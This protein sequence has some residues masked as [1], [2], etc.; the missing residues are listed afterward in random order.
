[1]NAQIADVPNSMTFAVAELGAMKSSVDSLAY[2]RNK[3]EQN[4]TAK[5]VVSFLSQMARVRGGKALNNIKLTGYTTSYT[6]EEDDLSYTFF[7]EEATVAE[8]NPKIP[9]ADL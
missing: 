6:I 7:Y 1:M 2:S 3:T 8:K 9:T 4:K 5:L